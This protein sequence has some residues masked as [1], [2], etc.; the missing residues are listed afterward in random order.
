MAT[1]RSSAPAAKPK[2]RPAAKVAEVLKAARPAK[3]AKAVAKPAAPKKPTAKTRAGRAPAAAPSPLELALTQPG[4]PAG[5]RPTFNPRIAA[6][7]CDRVA[8]GESVRSI[9]R[10]PAMPSASTIF[11]W[12]DANEQFA[13]AY[14]RAKVIGLEVRADELLE[15]ADDGKSD[16][17]TDAMGNER[18][19][20]DVLARSKLRIE[21][22]K[23][24][25]ER[26]V[27]KKY[28]ATTNVNHTGSVGLVVEME[29][30]QAARVAQA[31]LDGCKE[32]PVA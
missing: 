23:W 12:L 30:D 3:P 26:L 31:V 18:V 4:M 25:L 2:V 16:K 6:D 21:T 29:A 22:R 19:D 15:I 24:L 27:A 5:N 8:E 1:K 32:E 14:A 11:N 20:N 17:Y 28:G 13:G 7:V 10:D 9:A